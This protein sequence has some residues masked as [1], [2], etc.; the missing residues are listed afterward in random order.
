MNYIICSCPRSGS[1]LLSEALTAMGAGRPEEY[2]NPVISSDANNKRELL[3]QKDFML[4]TPEAFVG[5][6]RNEFTV[7]G[8]FGIKTHYIHLARIPEVLSNFPQIFPDAKFISV[9]RRNI[10]RQAISASRATQ[11][12]AWTAALKEQKRARFSYFSILKHLILTAQEI[13][14]WEK[15]YEKHGIKPLR[16]LYEELDQNYEE[17]M[18]K[19]IAFLGLTGPIPAQPLKKQSDQL[20]EEWT[21]RSANALR[22]N[23]RLGAMCRFLAQHL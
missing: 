18:K 15:F 6:I 4:P 10:L 17:T 23:S 20:T 11:T 7:N 8:I 13:E 12:Q 21:K 19:V 22:G 5:R 2:F 3:P 1:S 14:L 9:T 16:I